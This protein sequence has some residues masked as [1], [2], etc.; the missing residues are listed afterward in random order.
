MPSGLSYLTLWTGPFPIYGVFDLLFGII[1]Y[2]KNSC[3]IANSIGPDQTPQSGSSLFVN[4]L[5][6]VS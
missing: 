1:I 3:T 5:E 4:V 2:Y 6:E